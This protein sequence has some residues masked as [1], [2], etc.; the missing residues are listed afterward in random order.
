[1]AERRRLQAWK[2]LETHNIIQNGRLPSDT[3]G[4]SARHST[5]HL[6]DDRK[7]RGIIQGR[8]V[9]G[10]PSY[11]I[12]F[13]QDGSKYSNKPSHVVRTD[14]GFWVKINK[15]DR[16]KFSARSAIWKRLQTHTF[17]PSSFTTVRIC[18][19][20]ILAKMG[21]GQATD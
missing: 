18:P 15:I 13:H 3:H 6:Q 12:R 7:E 16:E 21:L 4:L 17:Y 20:S 11:E 10:K 8:K 1:M 14:N 5:S 9:N 19:R 2:H